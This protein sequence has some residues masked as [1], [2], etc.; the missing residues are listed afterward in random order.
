VDHRVLF[1]SLTLVAVLLAFGCPE[2]PPEVRIAE[3]RAQYSLHSPHFLVEE[4]E[5]EEVLSA[6]DFESGE[7]DAM[8]PMEAEAEGE[9]E[10]E[11]EEGQM[12][13]EGPRPVNVLFDVMVNFEG[14]RDG[15]P[16][17]TL[18]ITHK[19]PFDQVKADYRQWVDTTK[20]RKGNPQQLSFEREVP[21]FESGDTFE[22]ELRGYVP[23]DEWGDYKEFEGVASAP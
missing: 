7:E 16:G 4:T 6:E 8:E 18:D 12:E 23:P 13:P 10:G 1:R 21:D 17:I 19:D 15:L 9:G 3:T 11:G 14:L 22:I 5:A 20:V 2:Q